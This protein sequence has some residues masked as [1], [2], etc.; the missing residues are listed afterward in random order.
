MEN[1]LSVFSVTGQSIRASALII[2]G[3]KNE[4]EEFLREF[5]GATFSDG[6]Y[7]IHNGYSG[8]VADGC[9][10]DMFPRL[11]GYIRCFS[12]DWMGRQFALVLSGGRIEPNKV[13][14]VDPGFHE[15][16]EIPMG[17]VGFHDSELVDH[18]DAAILSG[19]YAEW[20]NLDAGV[21]GIGLNECVG[22]SVPPFLGGAD[23]V[24]NLR[25]QDIEVYWSFHSQIYGDIAGSE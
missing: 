15:I 10:A 25:I 18:P 22:Y 5:S 4:H 16:L 21:R 1:F 9:V 7:R 19:M 2:P 20:R 14:L 12:M 24:E 3:I 23:S 6:V 11:R 8:G 13:L 17:F